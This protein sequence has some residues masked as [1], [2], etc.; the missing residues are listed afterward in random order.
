MDGWVGGWMD[1]WMGEWPGGWV[2]DPWRHRD[3]NMHPEG[4]MPQPQATPDAHSGL[5]LSWLAVRIIPLVDKES[6]A[7]VC[8][9]LVS[10]RMWAG[11]WGMGQCADTGVLTLQ[12]SRYTVA[13]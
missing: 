10:A 11:L 5:T 9:I 1:G 13:S 8:V 4:S 6:G 12:P 2:G 3:D 7:V